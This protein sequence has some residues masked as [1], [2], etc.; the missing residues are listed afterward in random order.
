MPYENEIDLGI[1]EPQ[2]EGRMG[3]LLLAL[4]LCSVFLLSLGAYG[5]FAREAEKENGNLP[6]VVGALRKFAAENETVAVFL[7]FSPEED[8]RTTM[9]EENDTQSKADAYIR[10]HQT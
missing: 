2:E 1:A 7:G 6:A 10:E 3:I 5:L 8:A 9:K 4:L